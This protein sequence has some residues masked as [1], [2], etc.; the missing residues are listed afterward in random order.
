MQLIKLVV[1]QPT[2]IKKQDDE[3]EPIFKQSGSKIFI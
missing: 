1:D 3:Q 2:Y